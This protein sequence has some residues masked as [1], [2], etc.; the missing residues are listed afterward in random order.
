M[1][2]TDP[3]RLPLADT[4]EALRRG[5]EA[6]RADLPSAQ[7]L[8]ALA[9]RLPLAGNGPEGGGDGGSTPTPPVAP[10]VGGGASALRW[11]LPALG[12]TVV[13]V[14]AVF[15]GLRAPSPP[16]T[17]PAPAL[18]EAALAPPSPEAVPPPP[19]PAPPRPPA[20]PPAPAALAPGAVVPA[21]SPA[22]TV[23][24]ADA[25]PGAPPEAT[26]AP[27]DTL[28]AELALLQA[29]QAALATDPARALVLT[30][31]H[32][33]EFPGG[34]L[35]QE[36]EVVAIAALVALDRREDARERAAAFRARWPGSAHQRRVDASISG[37]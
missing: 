24:P 4:P 35:A 14:L 13:A 16:V 9:A 7:Q 31:Q 36:R 34:A 26:V 22:P 15:L 12:G 17:P 30:E 32:L 25:S 18:P 1:S 29:A 27:A 11:L 23:L 5:V 37:G 19:A 3:P 2:E 33:G 28:S 21:V 20:V 10:G 8:A 6:A